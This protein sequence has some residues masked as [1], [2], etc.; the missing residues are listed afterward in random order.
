MSGKADEGIVFLGVLGWR[1]QM[2]AEGNVDVNDSDS[3]E[4]SP[5]QALRKLSLHG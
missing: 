4:A 5:P 3:P 1:L 2:M